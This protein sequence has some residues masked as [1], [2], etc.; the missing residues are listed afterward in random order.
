MHCH[1]RRRKSSNCWVV[2]G[3]WSGFTEKSISDR[4]LKNSS[5]LLPELFGDLLRDALSL[6]APQI[7]QLLGRSGPLVWIYGEKHFRSDSEE[8]LPAFTGALRRFAQRCTVTSGA[9]NRATVG[10]FGAAGLDL[11]RKAFPIGL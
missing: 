6:P 10:S 11:R 9:A 8:L 1:F 5:R 2:R 7:E 4:T 3:R